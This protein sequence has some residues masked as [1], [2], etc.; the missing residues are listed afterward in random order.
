MSGSIAAIF[1]DGDTTSPDG[2]GF[3]FSGSEIPFLSGDVVSFSG[4]VV[5]GF[6]LDDLSASG[7][8]FIG[9][10]A[11]SAS[12]ASLSD[13]FSL[14]LTISET[15]TV[16]LP[17]GLALLA[18]GLGALGLFSRRRR[19][20]S[21]ESR[22]LRPW[23]SRRGTGKGPHRLREQRRAA[24]M[25]CPDLHAGMAANKADDPPP[26]MGIARQ[27]RHCRPPLRHDADHNARERH[28]AHGRKWP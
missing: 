5:V 1:V 19:R 28:G 3:L 2:V 12:N 24:G 21:A 6:Y 23:P 9:T 14:T 15:P 18:A 8:P 11:P 4:S 13:S 17:A 20:S 16:P 27:A 22:A 10:S 7:L 25:P 26:R